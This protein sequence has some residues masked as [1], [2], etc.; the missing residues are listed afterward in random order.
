MKKFLFVANRFD[1]EPA[2]GTALCHAHY[3]ALCS[4]FS[5]CDAQIVS[6]LSRTLKENP[7]QNKVSI[8]CSRSYFDDFVNLMTGRHSG[9]GTSNS[10]KAENEILRMLND[11]SYRFV[12]F[13]DCTYGSAVRKIK[14]VRPDIPVYVFYHIVPE[15]NPI[16][17]MI[18]D[19]FKPK[20]IFTALKN[21]NYMN[22]QKLSA[23]YADVNV[24]LNDRDNETF[25]RLY[26]SRE[27]LTLPVC[28]ID[29]ARS[30]HTETERESDEFNIFFIGIGMPQ[31]VKSIKWFAVNVMPGLNEK[32]KL[33]IAGNGMDKYKNDP[34]FKDNPRINV[35][36]RIDDLD[37]Y[38]NMADLVIVPTLYG[39]GMMT[40][41]AEALMHGKNILA[42]SHALN[43]YPE[44]ESQC[45][46]D[47]PEEF[48]TRIN[49]MIEKGTERYNPEMR[50]IF[51]ERYSLD[52][53]AGT[54]RE[55]L[56]R[57]GII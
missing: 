13:D 47:T 26:G 29:K 7:E 50:R 5:D 3:E 46:C 53:M 45:R 35:V 32:A 37:T 39:A 52:A 56:M 6:I 42:T 43:G 28:F 18:K 11:D 17:I 8:K 4:V 34:E 22:Q 2:G 30:I 9:H 25:S 10:I 54:L 20:R 16:N 33:I 21:K 23:E 19:I 57:R 41:V 1:D 55:D 48:I 44:I 40:K 15:Y 51:K 36:G 49:A 12:W 38:Y 27:R 24:L 14:R 31:N